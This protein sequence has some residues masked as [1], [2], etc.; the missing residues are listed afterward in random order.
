MQ[1]R[2]SCDKCSKSFALKS[3]LNRHVTS[4][5]QGY[6]C[7]CGKLLRTVEGLE[8]HRRI[9]HREEGGKEETAGA[10]VEGE[11][12]REGGWSNPAGV[13][14]GQGGDGQGGEGGGDTRKGERE[15]QSVMIHHHHYH[16]HCCGGGVSAGGVV[17]KEDP[18]SISLHLSQCASGVGDMGVGKGVEG[19]VSTTET[20]VHTHSHHHAHTHAHSQCQHVCGSAVAGPSSGAVVSAVQGGY[21][22]SGNSGCC[23][24]TPGADIVAI[25]GA[26]IVAVVAGSVSAPSATHGGKAVDSKHA[27]CAGSGGVAGQ[28]DAK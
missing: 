5:V 25:P 22:A 8:T 28:K 14:F 16:Y 10:K 2:Y 24:A 18:V 19:Q 17:G 26:D 27:G 12:G 13:V 6:T 20:H 1:E 11:Q 3:D 4:C 9:F 21:S 7:E 23:V 15:G